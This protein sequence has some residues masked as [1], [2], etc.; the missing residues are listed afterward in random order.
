MPEFNNQY[1]R[2]NTAEKNLNI[3]SQI[4]KFGKIFDEKTIK[5]LKKIPQKKVNPGILTKIM[6]YCR[7]SCL[8]GLINLADKYL[9]VH[10]K[11]KK[12]KFYNILS[13]CGTAS[14]VMSLLW[15]IL[16]MFGVIPEK[17][18]NMF[19]II[20]GGITIF[21]Y[22]TG[23]IMDILDLYYNPFNFRKILAASE[24]TI[25]TISSVIHMYNLIKN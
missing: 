16:E 19:K 1:S 11:I 8:S 4:I 14:T 12:L 23:L 9:S 15:W 7:N 20:D 25:S 6:D 10:R 24:I 22:L 3:A 5:S 2:L 13:G 17:K 21:G 18:S